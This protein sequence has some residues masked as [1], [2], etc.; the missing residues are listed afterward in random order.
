MAE[1]GIGPSSSRWRRYGPGMLFSFWANVG[2][3]WSVV[4]DGCKHAEAT[5][6]DG[7]WVADHFM[8]NIEGFAGEEDEAE[9]GPVM[10]AWTIIG[11]L[12]AAVPR[13]RIGTMVTGNTYRHPAV[14]ANMAATADHISGGRIVLGIGAGWQEN[15]HARYG[16][17]LGSRGGRSDRFEEACEII[18]GLF[19]NDRTSFDGEYY[20]LDGAPLEPKPVQDPMP[21]M[22][23]GGGEKRTMRT[24]ARFADEWNIWARPEDMRQKL[25]ILHRHCE[26]VGRDPA[27]I[28]VSACAMLVITDSEEHTEK[29]A[30]RMA[31]RGGLVGTVDQLRATIAEYEELGIDEI[32]VP[33]F[34]MTPENRA[35]TL[36][37]FRAEVI[38]A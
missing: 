11:A 29:V 32:V 9:L 21:L 7:I 16:M 3:P 31:H 24:A 23:G 34:T 2:N 6:W 27:E 22:I 18:K 37:R 20:N 4:L 5:G 36:D 17:E 10:E 12:G 14:L 38:D 28:H 30:G 35:D 19:A 1:R 26:D 8:P 25:P 15:E 13:V 33:D